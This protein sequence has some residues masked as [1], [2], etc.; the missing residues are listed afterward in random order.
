MLFDPSRGGDPI[1]NIIAVLHDARCSAPGTPL[2]ERK[3]GT[4]AM[5]LGACHALM[6]VARQKG[7]IHLTTFHITDE[8]TFS[9]PPISNKVRTYGADVLLQDRTY[10][11]RH[12]NALPL[13]RLVQNAADAARARMREAVD[14]D[15]RSFV[16]AMLAYQL[17]KYTAWLVAHADEIESAVQDAF[18]ARRTWRELFTSLGDGF[19]CEFFACCGEQLSTMFALGRLMGAAYGVTFA[20]VPGGRQTTTPDSIHVQLGGE[21]RRVILARTSRMRLAAMRARARCTL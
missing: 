21:N 9:C 13:S 7:W 5:M 4:R 1:V 16:D 17:P 12:L 10:Y 18:D 15:G 3:R 19:G 14:M 20:D 2:L 8:S 6:A 11:E